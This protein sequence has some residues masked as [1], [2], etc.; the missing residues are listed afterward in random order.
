MIEL[1][2]ESLQS[3]AGSFGFIFALML[4]AGWVIY[5]VTKKVTEINV[6]HKGLSTS[7]VKIEDNLDKIREDIYYLKGT[8][9]IIKSGKNPY[10]KAKSPISLTELGI[11][12][13][14]EL[15]VSGMISRNWERIYKDLEDN[16]QDKNAYDI[17]QYCM[18]TVAVKPDR[19]LDKTDIEK[20]KNKAF[21]DGNS[22][23]Y[24]AP[25]IGIPIRD[26]YFE[27]KGINLADIDK[28]DPGKQKQ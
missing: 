8:I 21:L 20:V 9:D 15:D 11:K 14:E 4:L 26:K 27:C 24:Y 17:Q 16:I 22:I 1:L 3:P 25:V 6:S 23:I 19:F 5:Y 2:K 28:H 13:A 12:V 18:D 10:A 7:I